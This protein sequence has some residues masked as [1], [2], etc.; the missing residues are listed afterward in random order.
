MEQVKLWVNSLD[1]QQCPEV[2][3]ALALFQ[4]VYH[5]LHYLQTLWNKSVANLSKELSSYKVCLNTCISL[6]NHLF[7]YLIGKAAI[8]C[9]YYGRIINYS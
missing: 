3:G 7:L 1:L 4:M 9:L 8:I 5:L 6:S 2:P